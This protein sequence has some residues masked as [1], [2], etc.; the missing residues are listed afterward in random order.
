MSER[1]KREL[2]Q[3]EAEVIDE[4]YRR[5]QRYEVTNGYVTTTEP[6]PMGSKDDKGPWGGNP[7][8]VIPPGSTIKIVMV[9]RMGD[10]GLTDD[11]TAETGYH[12]R[13][14]WNDAA[15]S[16]IRLTKNP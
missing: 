9:S 14:D 16:D 10:C 6:I 4:L 11:L 7:D 2:T 1:A 5:K 3:S 13:L 12:V 8:R 15:M